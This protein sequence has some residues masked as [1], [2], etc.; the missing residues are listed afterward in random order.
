MIFFL[1]RKYFEPK[2]TL[3]P[4]PENN[5]DTHK[6]V[7]VKV[8]RSINIYFVQI[9]IQSW[10]DSFWC[11]QKNKQDVNNNSKRNYSKF[12]TEQEQLD[13]KESI[14]SDPKRKKGSSTQPKP[15]KL[16]DKKQLSKTTKL[17]GEKQSTKSTKLVDEKQLSKYTKT[18]KK[19]G[20]SS[21]ETDSGAPSTSS[22]DLDY[23]HDTSMISDSVI[24]VDSSMASNNT[25][26]G[27]D[28]LHTD[29]STEID[30]DQCRT[31]PYWSL[32]N[33]RIAIVIDQGDVTTNVVDRFFG[34]KMEAPKSRQIFP[35]SA[36]IPRRRSTAVWNTPPRYSLMPK[37]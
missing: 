31:K 19:N 20:S 21:S 36:A 16:V 30:E 27:F 2:R 6:K 23:V 17:V 1:Q 3:E 10:I 29:D 15:T 28:A 11:L 35:K 32:Y 12:S 8:S 25:L 4:I 33:N 5:E 22:S 18:A 37:Y 34:C 26:D 13:E 24:V 14:G 7:S 9:L